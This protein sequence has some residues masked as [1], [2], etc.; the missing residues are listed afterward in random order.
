LEPWRFGTEGHEEAGPPQ[1]QCPCQ[2]L[3]LHALFYNTAVRVRDLAG[4]FWLAMLVF[5][6]AGSLAA[7]KTRAVNVGTL[8]THTPLFIPALLRTVLI[9]D[10]LA[11]FRTLALGPI[12]ERLL[13]A[14]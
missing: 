8:P 4:R 13:R 6:I 2:A 1:S 11:F 3:D 10:G 9:A 14:D 5:G 12:V 7:K